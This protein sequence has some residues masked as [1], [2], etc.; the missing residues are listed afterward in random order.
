MYGP[1][2]TK[3]SQAR[4]SAEAGPP[5]TS[6]IWAFDRSK[7]RS[8]GENGFDDFLDVEGIRQGRKMVRFAAG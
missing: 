3:R 4:Q 1:F 6:Q 5:S 2:P 8:A 7:G